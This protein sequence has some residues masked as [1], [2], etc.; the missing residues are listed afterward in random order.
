ML[1]NSTLEKLSALRLPEMAAAWQEQQR[2]T[3]HDT[4]TFDERFGL[5]V[6]AL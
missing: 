5:L 1:N 3:D 4:L 6:D 2:R